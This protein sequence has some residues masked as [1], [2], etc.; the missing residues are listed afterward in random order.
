LLDL[1][2]APERAAACYREAVA[3]EP[4]CAEPHLFLGVHLLA[5]GD[6]DAASA[7]LSRALFLDPDLALAHYFLGRCREA[8]HDLGRAR[9]SYRNALAAHDRCPAGHR[10][11][12]LGHYPDLP[13]GGAAFARA[14]R[15]ALDA[16]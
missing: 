16:L 5:R 14:A 8:Q 13:E 9:L 3:K 10:Q 7:E 15:Y 4:L 6:P 12:F 1:L 11:R 2:Q